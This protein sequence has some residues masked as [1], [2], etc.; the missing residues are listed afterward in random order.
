MGGRRHAYRRIRVPNDFL[1]KLCRESDGHVVH[2][3]VNAPWWE[4]L[5]WCLRGLGSEVHVRCDKG[6]LTRHTDPDLH[7][8]GSCVQCNPNVI[9]GS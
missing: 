3:A 7:K 8:R 5:K 9:Y 2:Y 4:E 1:C 6:Y